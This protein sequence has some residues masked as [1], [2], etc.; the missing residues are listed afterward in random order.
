[1]KKDR[2]AICDIVSEML[3]NPSEC[4][5]YPTTIAYDKLEKYIEGVRDNAIAETAGWAHAD[6]CVDLDKGN[7]PREKECSE[8]LERAF[9]DLKKVKNRFV[10]KSSRI[11]S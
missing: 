11:E 8:M 6:A 9:R 10:Q 1:M 7:D 2:K 3:D 5:I 4:E